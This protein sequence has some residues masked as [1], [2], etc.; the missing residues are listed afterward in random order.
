[1]NILHASGFAE[2][3]ARAEAQNRALGVSSW[4]PELEASTPSCSDS[5]PSRKSSS[6]RSNHKL[7]S[8]SKKGSRSRKLKNGDGK[9][10]KL[11]SSRSK[12][13]EATAEDHKGRN[14]AEDFVAHYANYKSMDTE[15]DILKKHLVKGT[16]N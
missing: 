2:W 3:A 11:R 16:S 12:T 8:T 5:K 6:S 13:S 4:Q 9:D 15:L 14:E 1:M 10:S 7:S